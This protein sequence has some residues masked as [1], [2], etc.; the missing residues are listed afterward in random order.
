MV[1]FTTLPLETDRREAEGEEDEGKVEGEDEDETVT[2]FLVKV[3]LVNVDMSLL[4][5]IME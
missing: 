2:A 5:E 3:D 1:S 4:C